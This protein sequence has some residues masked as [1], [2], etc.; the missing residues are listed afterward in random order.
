MRILLAVAATALLAPAV[1]A[2]PIMLDFSGNICTTTAGGPMGATCGNTL[3]ISQDY[4]DVAGQ[5]DVIYN[6]NR[7]TSSLDELRFW[8][9]GYESLDQVAYGTLGGGGLSILFQPLS[10]YEVTITGFDIAPYANRSRDTLVQVIDTAT[11]MFLLDQAFEPLPTGTVTSF[12]GSWT[13]A[14]GIQINLGPDAWDVGISNIVGSVTALGGQGPIAPIPLPA[15]A[16]LMLG[17]IG[18]LGMVARRGTR[19]RLRA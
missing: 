13:S 17:A 11:N 1:Q 12:S 15:A 10:G 2:T 9:S 16:W 6:S 19:V 3:R 14:A 7:N 4:G 8:G 18:G 5:L